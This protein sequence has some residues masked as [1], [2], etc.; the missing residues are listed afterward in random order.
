VAIFFSFFGGFNL[1]EK[2]QV[3]YL[4]KPKE[5]LR[6]IGATFVMAFLLLASLGSLAATG[7]NPFIYFRF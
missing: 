4:E 6:L 3:N 5:G 1:V 2:W 7:F